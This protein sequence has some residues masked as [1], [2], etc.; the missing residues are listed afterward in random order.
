MYCAACDR[1]EDDQIAVED[2]ICTRCWG[3]LI[4]P[5]D[6]DEDCEDFAS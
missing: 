4:E 5:D 1:W 6:I 2:C 3:P